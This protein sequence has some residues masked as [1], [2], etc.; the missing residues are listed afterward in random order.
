M[1]ATDSSLMDYVVTYGGPSIFMT[2]VFVFVLPLVYFKFARPRYARWPARLAVLL[3]VWCLAF[4][5]AYGDVFLIARDAKRLCETEAG[6]KIYRTVEAEG[7]AGVSSIETWAPRGF[8]FVES[9]TSN[10]EK[11]RHEVVDGSVRKLKIDEYKSFFEYRTQSSVIDSHLVRLAES[12][13]VI[14]SGETLAEIVGF[15]IFPGWI[16][17]AL[18]RLIGFSWHPAACYGPTKHGRSES[19][20]EFGRVI[21]ASIFPLKK[22]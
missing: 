10:G 9:Q 8:R 14:S 2:A 16:D 22:S 19:A 6:M 5:V 11:F 13:E 17:R 20:G 18:I 1:P 12:V 15:R 7:F 4:G 3:G 21:S